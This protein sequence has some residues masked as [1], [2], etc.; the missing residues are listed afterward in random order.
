MFFY[1]PKQLS[2]RF[3]ILY[4]VVLLP[5]NKFKMI[6]PE[7]RDNQEGLLESVKNLSNQANRLIRYLVWPGEN[8]G[9]ECWDLV[10]RACIF[11]DHDSP[12]SSH[13]LTDI[14]VDALTK[15]R[16]LLNQDERFKERAT[17]VDS[18]IQNAD[19]ISSDEY[20]KAA[21]IVKASKTY[22]F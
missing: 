18:L 17:I 14:D 7:K 15:L 21:E 20:Q 19:L 3:D 1:I 10:N 22:R 9:R 12:I 4:T 11:E 5:L 6:N 16:D 13:V 8:D 2:N